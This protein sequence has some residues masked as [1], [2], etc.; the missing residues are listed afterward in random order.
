MYLRGIRG[1]DADSAYYFALR[2][3]TETGGAGVPGAGGPRR[4]G[5]QYLGEYIERGWIAE[6][7]VA[8]PTTKTEVDEAK[9]AVS[10]TIEYAYSDYAVALFA[11]AMGDTDNYNLL[12]Q[13]S[14]NY[15]N[16]FDPSTR[17]IRGRFDNG[18]WVT[19]FYP[20]YPYYVFMYR[21]STGWQSTFF[22]PQDPLGL[23]SLFPDK[24]AFEQ[25]LDSLFIVPWGGYE[26]DNFTG[27]FGQYCVGNQPSQQI[28]YMYYFIDKQ[29]KCQEK[30]DIIMD[31]YYNMGKEGLAYAGMDDEGGLSA[32]YVL[33][34]IGLY[35]FSPAD[36]EY[37]VTVPIF[38]RVVFDLNDTPFTISKINNGRKI[39]NITYDGKKIDGYFVSHDDLKKGKELIITTE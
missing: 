12:M 20:D 3:A 18:D 35:S 24:K 4:G 9:A 8:N 13:R 39:S 36:P 15:K 16:L 38:D 5:R 33:N 26:A 25:K 19:P 17:F 28:A 27:F 23:I 2:N 29:E 37:I 30:L 1:Y 34:A 6:N 14:K 31:K 10:K 22:A 7:H 32:W 11:K 21:E